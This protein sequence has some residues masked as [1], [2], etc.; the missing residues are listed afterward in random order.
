V[1]T[2]GATW[3][4]E[5]ALAVEY[6]EIPLEFQPLASRAALEDLRASDDPPV[7]RKADFLLARLDQGEAFDA[8]YSCP[9]QVARFGKSLCLIA[10]GG[11]PVVDY[12]QELKR[13]YSGAG[14]VV[15]VAGYANDMFGYVPSARVL[16]EGGYEGNRSLLWSALPA[17]FAADIE[18]R[19]LAGIDRLV[20]RSRK[21]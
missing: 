15:W 5:G 10:I 18:A 3:P 12:S 19:V 21:E 20:A 11:E 4:V 14:R 9:L 1:R 16:R 7:R 2:P 17:P 8:S 13:R 6:D